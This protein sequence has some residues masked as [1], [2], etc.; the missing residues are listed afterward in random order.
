LVAR[1]PDGEYVAIGL[2]AVRD[3]RGWIGGMATAPTW[4]RQGIGTRLLQR[5]ISQADSLGLKTIEL[6]VLEENMAAH[7]LYRQAGFHDVRPLSVF[8][9]LLA[10][11]SKITSMRDPV[12]EMSET[13]IM[14]VEPWVLLQ[15][16]GRFHQVPSAWQRH[17]STLLR[18]APRLHGLAVSTNAG[19]E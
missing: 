3:T 14:E 7:R 13:L 15:D 5:L 11:G 8:A 17:V 9:G 1:A 19:I 2:L 18:L 16:F 4:R 6:E 12:D 10:A